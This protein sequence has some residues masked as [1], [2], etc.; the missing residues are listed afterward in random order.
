VLGWDFCAETVVLPHYGE[1][2]NFSLTFALSAFFRITAQK[3]FTPCYG[4]LTG[5]LPNV[6]T[7]NC[8]LLSCNL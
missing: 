3:I 5:I 2:S 4:Q 7:V 1:S 8:F 6:G